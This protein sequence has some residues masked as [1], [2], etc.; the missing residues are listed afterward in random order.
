M[1]RKSII[2]NID[3]I[4]DILWNQLEIEESWPLLQA[5]IKD[6]R[7]ERFDLWLTIGLKKLAETATTVAQNNFIEIFFRNLFDTV[8]ILM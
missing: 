6:V 8:S 5:I 1:G 7:G 3:K 2:Y 4:Y